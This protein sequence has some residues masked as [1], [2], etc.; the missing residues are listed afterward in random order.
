MSSPHP[1]SSPLPAT[2][3][4]WVQ[5]EVL[6]R[7]PELAGRLLD[8]APQH[9]SS[10][11]AAERSRVPCRS[12]PHASVFKP[13]FLALPCADPLQAGSVSLLSSPRPLGEVRWKHSPLRM[14]DPPHVSSFLPCRS[15]LECSFFVA[16]AICLSV[17]GPE[18]HLSTPRLPAVCWLGFIYVPN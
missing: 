5:G 18:T 16:R 10:R 3:C 8:T 4:L 14:A 12:S 11:A 17:P 15:I 6:K 2:M 7:T 13:T 9:L 1:G